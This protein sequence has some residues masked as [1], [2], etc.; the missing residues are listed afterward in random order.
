MATVTVSFSYDTEKH[1]RL[2]RWLEGLP[3]RGKS[4]ALRNALNDHLGQNGITL[5]DIYNEIQDLKRGG[6]AVVSEESRPQADIP[7]DVLANLSKL[8]L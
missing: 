1:K 7:A 2:H 5:R 3:N 6:V 4:E 8:G